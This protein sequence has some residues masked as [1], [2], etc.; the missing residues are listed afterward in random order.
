MQKLTDVYQGADNYWKIYSDNF[1]QGA[2]KSAFGNPETLVKGSK[3]YGKFMTNVEDWYTTVAGQRF[4]KIDPLTGIEKT[5]LQA[6][7]DASAYLVT[8]TIPT[9][10]KV[11]MIIEDIRNLPL[12]NFVAF[13]AEILRTTANIVSIG[14]RELTSTNPFIRQMGARRLIGV[15]SVLGG[16]GYSVQKRSSVYDRSR[17]RYYESI[18][19]FICT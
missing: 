12:G 11:P 3:E 19:K 9:Y 1:Y 15:S 16:I 7:E 4:I 6:L 14:A 18:S 5:P 2:L 17:R 10:S 13:P 8:N